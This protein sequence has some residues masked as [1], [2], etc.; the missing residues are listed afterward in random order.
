MK[1]RVLSLLL[2]LFIMGIIFYFSA[3]P[4][5]ESGDLSF[6]WSKKLLSWIEFL[7]SMKFSPTKKMEIAQVIELPLR[8]TAH[9]LEYAALGISVE[10]HLWIRAIQNQRISKRWGIIFCSL[11]ALSDEIHQ[12]F[13]PGRACRIYDVILDSAGAMTGVFLMAAFLAF[14]WKASGHR[15]LTVAMEERTM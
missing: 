8:K 12:Y 4:A 7:F 14:L 3:A 5:E 10:L 6:T 2:I 15:D 13:V 9:F 11:Y 1:K